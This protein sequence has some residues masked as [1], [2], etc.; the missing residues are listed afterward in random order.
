MS[1]LL[2]LFAFIAASFQINAQTHFTA[3][4]IIPEYPKQSKKLSF[5]YNQ[6]NSSLIKQPTVKAVVYLFSDSGIK[7]LEPVITKKGAI[8]LGYITVDSNTNCIAFDFS[9]ARS[10]GFP[11][12]RNMAV[13]KKDI[14]GERDNVCFFLSRKTG[15]CRLR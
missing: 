11:G 3:L 9:S 2:C 15:A 7:A 13:N 6:N 12:R 10:R 8:Y 4:K 5:E 1:K 14:D